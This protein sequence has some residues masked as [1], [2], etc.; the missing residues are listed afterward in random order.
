[1]RQPGPVEVL[2]A[3]QPRTRWR[4]VLAWGVVA[5]L[6]LAIPATWAAQSAWAENA[7]GTIDTMRDRGVN[8]AERIERDR[9][10][11][12]AYAGPLLESPDP[13]VQA[14]IRRIMAEAS[15]DGRAALLDSISGL[16]AIAILPWQDDVRKQREAALDELRELARDLR[17]EV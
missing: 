11:I 1:M 4:R 13:A 10:K 15:P 17:I 5:A 8:S 14:E 16:E 3:T 6:L 12:A 9:V 2:E 7:M